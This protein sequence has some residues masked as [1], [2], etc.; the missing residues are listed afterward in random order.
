MVLISEPTYQVPSTFELTPEKLHDFLS[1]A[2]SPSLLERRSLEGTDSHHSDSSE[3]KD[4]LTNGT[5]K[6][7]NVPSFAQVSQHHTC[8]YSHL[9]ALTSGSV[10]AGSSPEQV[11]CLACK[12]VIQRYMTRMTSFLRICLKMSHSSRLE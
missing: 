12:A 11:S 3:V 5:A 7:G 8:I 4:G 6:D 1:L 10:I 2:S 9:S